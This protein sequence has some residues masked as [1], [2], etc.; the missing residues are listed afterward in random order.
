MTGASIR[1]PGA[2]RSG[3]S[4]D[5]A[6]DV[7]VTCGAVVSS[8]PEFSGSLLGLLN[9][10]K[11]P[12]ENLLAGP[13]NDAGMRLDMFERFAQIAQAMRCAHDVRVYHQRHDPRRFRCISIQLLKLVDGPLPVFSCRVVLNQ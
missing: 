1:V 5:L 10:A 13:V 4:Q 7:F 9:S 6:V 11:V 3:G 12:F 8:S 2:W